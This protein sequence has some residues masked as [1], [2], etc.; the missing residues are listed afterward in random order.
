LSGDKPLTDAPED[1]VFVRLSWPEAVLVREH[2]G[3]I[4]YVYHPNSSYEWYATAR[5]V[6]RT[7]IAC[8]V[9]RAGP[10]QQSDPSLRKVA[11][12]TEAMADVVEGLRALRRDIAELDGLLAL[13]SV[14]A[15]AAAAQKQRA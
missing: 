8:D 5:D 12:L 3:Q 4:Y 15:A 7:Q 10:N 14:W 6:I 11:D 9:L 13:S 2:C 1:R